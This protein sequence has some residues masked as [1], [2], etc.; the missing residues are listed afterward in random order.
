VEGIVK[1]SIIVPVYNAEKFLDKCLESLKNQ[2][3]KDIEIILVND[4]STDNSL[5]ICNKYAQNDSRIKVLTQKNSGQSKARNVGI[6]NSNGEY[7][8]FTDSDDWVDL[9]Y[10]EKLVESCEKHDAEIA[11][12]SII[13]ERKNTRKYRVKYTET[14]DV[15]DEQEKID[16]AR[17][18]NMCYVF[19]KVYKKSLLERLNLRFI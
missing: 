14:L 12:A 5:E 10:Y 3:I 8:A 11:C 9:D 2:T 4:G 15:T 13:R 6:D 7:I 17:V 19:N 16:V 18:P 1:L